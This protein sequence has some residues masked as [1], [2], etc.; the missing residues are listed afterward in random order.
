MLNPLLSLENEE[1]LIRN[2][3]VIPTNNLELEKK[4]I[5]AHQQ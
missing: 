4:F 1:E 3:I 2:Y 5:C